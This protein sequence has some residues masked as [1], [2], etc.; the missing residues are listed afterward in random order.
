MLIFTFY[1]KNVHL[2]PR[3]VH[4][5]YIIDMYKVPRIM[6]NKVLLYNYICMLHVH[7]LLFFESM[8]GHE[9]LNTIV[10]RLGVFKY[11]ICY[12][13]SVCI[14]NMMFHIFTYN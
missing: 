7:A 13:M 14:Q 4:T 9:I 8:S 3:I 11:N 10:Q 12:I 1:S 6:H 2:Q 5:Q